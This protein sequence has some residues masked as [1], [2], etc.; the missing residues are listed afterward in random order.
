MQ[1]ED[2]DITDDIL[3]LMDLGVSEENI[4]LLKHISIN[5]IKT[6]VKDTKLNIKKGKKGNVIQ[7]I[8]NQNQW[9]ENPPSPAKA[10]LIGEQT[11]S[12]DKLNHQDYYYTMTKPSK[13]ILG[14]DRSDKV[15]EDYVLESKLNDDNRNIVEQKK[16]WSKII[17]ELN[18]ILDD[19]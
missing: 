10:R 12:K 19:G 4:A 17:N 11:W 6:I 8:G 13:T 5:D 15:G 1:N 14:V 2:V 18:N 16:L 9:R 3:F 7:D